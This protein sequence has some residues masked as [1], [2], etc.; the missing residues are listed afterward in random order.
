MSAF[1]EAI[2][3]FGGTQCQT[4]VRWIVHTHDV[5]L[6]IVLVVHQDSVHTLEVAPGRYPARK[7]SGQRQ[8]Q[9]RGDS[10][11]GREGGTEST[12]QTPTSDLKD[13][14]DAFV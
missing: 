4:W 9:G 11:K 1:E 8:G 5:L 7:D 14:K 3:K 13:L 6:V 10:S 2:G 12:D